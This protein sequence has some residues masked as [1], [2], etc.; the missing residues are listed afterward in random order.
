MIV[1]VVLASSFESGS[2]SN[3]LLIGVPLEVPRAL[4]LVF[5]DAIRAAQCA[6]VLHATTA[7]NDDIFVLSGDILGDT[8]ELQHP[9]LF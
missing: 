9:T 1:F 7:D 5:R 2:C 4:D 3:I 6:L 8:L